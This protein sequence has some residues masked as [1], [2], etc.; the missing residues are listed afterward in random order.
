M[1][2]VEYDDVLSRIAETVRRDTDSRGGVDDR[3]GISLSGLLNADDGVAS[4]EGRVP[5]MTTNKPEILD[6]AL[7]RPG[8][9]NLQVE[10]AYATEEQARKLFEDVRGRLKRFF[11]SIHKHMC[12][13]YVSKVGLNICNTPWIR[14]ELCLA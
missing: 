2:V 13:V 10:F 14:T 3:K 9:V 7:I 1:W 11:Y 8:R 5:I 6:D 4:H 12:H